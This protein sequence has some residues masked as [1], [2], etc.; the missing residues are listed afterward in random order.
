MGEN[1][2]SLGVFLVKF[3]MKRLLLTLGLLQ[4]NTNF[5]PSITETDLTADGTATT[6][7]IANGC[8][9]L[10]VYRNGLRLR[11]NVDY[12]ITIDGMSVSIPGVQSGDYITGECFR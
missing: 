8:K 5:G 2:G 4:I 1:V 6:F 10:A 12:S 9:F 7:P 3:F 11:M